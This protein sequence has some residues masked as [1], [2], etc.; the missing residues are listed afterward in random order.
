LSAPQPPEHHNLSRAKLKVAAIEGVRW[1]ALARLAAELLTVGSSIVLAHLVSPRQFG[2]LAV[3]VIVRELALMTAN[4][5]VG[6]PL[7]QRREISRAHLEAGVMLALGMGLALSLFT[8]LVVPLATTPLFGAETTQLFRLF[9]PSFLLVAI[10]IVPLAQLQRELR[11]RRIGTIE[12]C[13]VLASAAVSLALAFAGLEAKAYVLGM[14]T[15]LAVLAVGYQVSVPRR[16]P[17]WHRREA[18]EIRRFGVPA[19]AAGLAGIGYRNVDYIV[20]GGRLGPLM[21]GY[22]Y[23]AY[24]LGVE[25]EA[26]LTGVLARVT[27]PLYSRTEDLDHLRSLRLRIVRLNAT[28]VW[29]LLACFIVIAPVAVPWIFGARWEPAVV[30]A[31]LLAVAGMASTLRNG[32]SPLILAAG[33]PRALLGFCAVEAVAY[34]GTVWAASFAG[35]TAVAAAVSA[36]QV[37]AL[38]A[39]YAVM[40]GPMVGVPLRQLTRDV[41]PAG[42]CSLA[43]VAVGWPLARTLTGALPAL[44]FVA[45]V[46]LACAVVYLVAL[47]ALFPAAW[48]DLE[49]LVRSLLRRPP[50]EASRAPLVPATPA[51]SR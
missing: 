42:I 43:L 13:G 29:P 12:V 32:T 35:L 46:S 6:S 15:G 22:Y 1:M 20:I 44:P 33:H 24:T 47:R 5:G 45:V 38:C 4:E 18:R 8:L 28:L 31:Q 34:A 23:R 10:M 39:A 17:R 40:L 41:A 37:V 36:F 21:A 48:S 7:V 19:A 9:S 27:F 51:A 14:L 11:F 3:A 50:P 30:P 26:K 49:L 16:L 25:Y 2:M